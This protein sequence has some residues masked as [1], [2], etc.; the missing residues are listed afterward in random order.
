[1]DLWLP[2]RY[3]AR[4][5]LL[6]LF[7]QRFQVSDPAG[8]PVAFVRQKAFRLREDIRVYRSEEETEQLLWIR[9]RKILD[10]ASAYDV[11]EAGTEGKIGALR[12]RGFASLVRDQWEIFGPDDEPLGRVAEESLGLAL[13]RRLLSG[14]VPQRF[15]FFVDGRPVGHVRQRFNPF[16][17]TYDVDFTVDTARALPPPLG[18]AAVILLLAIEGRQE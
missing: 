6:T 10:F 9:A 1:M 17:L 5:R 4:K 12:R 7:G 16:V 15:T 8:G 11:V 14:L 13:V 18:L 3:V 2:D